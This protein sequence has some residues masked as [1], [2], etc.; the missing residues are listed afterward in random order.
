METRLE[1]RTGL[2]TGE[3]HTHTAVA[4][5][6]SAQAQLCSNRRYVNVTIIKKIIFFRKH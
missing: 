3:E 6:N 5:G 2:D 1:W 4:V